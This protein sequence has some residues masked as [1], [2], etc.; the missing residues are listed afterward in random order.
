MS[1]ETRSSEGDELCESCDKNHAGEIGTCP[2]FQAKYVGGPDDVRDKLCN[3]CN[4][5]YAKC[6]ERS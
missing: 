2:Y 6:K 1:D 3:C 5:C 4:E